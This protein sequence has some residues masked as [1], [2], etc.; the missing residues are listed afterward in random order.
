MTR[1]GAAGERL[2]TQL[3][4]A[5]GAAVWLPSFTLGAAPDAPLAGTRVQG[6][7][8]G[9]LVVFVSPAAVEF[10]APALPAAW[11]AAVA[12]GAVGAATGAAL[13]ARYPGSAL[14]LVVPD[15]DAADAGSEALLPALQATWRDAAVPRRVLL[16][17]ATHGREWLGERLRE[18]GAA[19]ETL[20]VYRRDPYTPSAAD[21][22][23]LAALLR[24]G[25]PLAT[26]LTSSEAVAALGVQL[27]A[28]P[29]VL[30]AV[31]RGSALVSHARI[32]AAAQAAGFADVR[33]AAP[34]AATLMAAATR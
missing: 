5:G 28:Q 15:V 23:A 25:A 12:I 16:V 10:A 7:A 3:Q 31:R 21:R 4:A 13:Q 29:E 22:D 14:P 34:D 6:L 11:P 32:A 26:V 9:D 17:R 24:T 20:A 33:I 18:H 30:A 19:V 27:A 8:P 1:P 2:A